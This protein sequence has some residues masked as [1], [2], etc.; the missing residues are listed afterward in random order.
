MLLLIWL[1][2]SNSFLPNGYV[3]GVSNLRAFKNIAACGSKFGQVSG[4]LLQVRM[5]DKRKMSWNCTC[6]FHQILYDFPLV[7]ALV[8]L[9]NEWV[10]RPAKLMEN[11]KDSIRHSHW[12]QNSTKLSKAWYIF[13]NVRRFVTPNTNTVSKNNYDFCNQYNRNYL[14]ARF[15]SEI[16]WTRLGTSLVSNFAENIF[17]LQ[18]YI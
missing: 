16:P 8:P 13:L 4:I 11:I 6:K 12:Q 9:Y 7:F 18:I 10:L 2:K 3:L 15:N 1:Q 17:Q 14:Y 5:P